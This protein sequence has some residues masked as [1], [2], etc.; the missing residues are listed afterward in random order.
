M[1][2]LISALVSAICLIAIYLMTLPRGVKMTWADPGGRYVHYFSYFSDTPIGYGNWMPILTAI[3]V[4]GAA[5]MLLLQIIKLINPDN[6]SGRSLICLIIA[7]LFSLISFIVFN[8]A[9]V[10]SSAI[11]G[12]IL[13][14]AILQYYSF[15]REREQ[16]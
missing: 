15:S 2:R 14:A 4:I 13:L 12:L 11:T 5:T 16:I 8:T 9:T 3:L 7:V 1:K 10:L 6:W